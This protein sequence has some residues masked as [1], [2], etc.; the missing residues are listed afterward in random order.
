M[1]IKRHSLVLLAAIGIFFAAAG[2]RG[3]EAGIEFTGFIRDEKGLSVAL[4]GSAS[5]NSK[6]VALG[7]EFED[8]TVRSFDEKAEVLVVSKDGAEFRL[9]LI[10]ARIKQVDSE[11]PPELKRKV[12]NNLRQLAAAAD[13]YYLE[14]GKTTTTYDDLVGPTKYVKAI[15]PADGE[16]YRALQFQQ[17]K[18]FQVTTNGGYVISYQP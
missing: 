4:R 10:R 7:Q 6:W 14:N 3:A 9:P 13:Q 18:G 2:L 5:G 16:N 15:D 11:P 17:G 12:L 8:Y 1:K